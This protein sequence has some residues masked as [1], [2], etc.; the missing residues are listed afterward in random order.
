MK[1]IIIIGEGQTE[2]VFCQKVLQPY[3]NQMDIFIETPTIKKS[4]GGIVS[5]PALKR[6]IENHLLDKEVIVTSLLDYYGIEPKHLFPKWTESLTIPNKNDRLDFLKQAMLEDISPNARHRFIPYLQ[7]HEFEGLLFCSQEIFDDFYEKNEFKDYAY[8]VETLNR[9]ENPE[10]IND[11]KET[12][13][14]Q[15]LA[16]IFVSYSKKTK[17]T[18]LA[19]LLGLS[20]IRDKC[21]RFNAW[22]DQLLKS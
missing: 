3:F 11:G 14:S 16:R 22:I 15:R 4:G 18:E 13:P 1:R 19:L 5:W 21:P 6:Q 20:I 9:Y 7:L 2:Q 12:I 10:M 8:L 17:G